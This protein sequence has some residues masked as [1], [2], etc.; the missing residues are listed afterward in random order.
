MCSRSGWPELR[1]RSSL[2][3]K[4]LKSDNGGECNNSRFEEFCANQ[5][6]KIVKTI[7]ENHHQNGGGGAHEHDYFGASQEHADTCRIAYVILGR[8]SQHRGISDQQRI[9]GASEL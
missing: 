4:C 2:K 1:M 6:I 8:C 3:L 5:G 7:S 9:F